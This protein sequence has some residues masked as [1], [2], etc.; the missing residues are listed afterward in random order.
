[1][2]LAKDVEEGQTVAASFNT[3]TLFTIAQDLT[4]MRVIAKVDEADIGEVK[5][6][7]RAT[8]TVDAYPND[9]FEGKVTQ[10]RQN[11]ETENNVV[12]YEVVISAPN[13]DLK[14]KPALTANVTLFTLEVDSVLSIPTKAFRFQPTLENL[15]KG[16]TIED[17]EGRQKIW[18]NRGNI[19]KAISIETGLTNGTRTEVLSGIN[20]GEEIIVGISMEAEAQKEAATERS[21]FAPGPPKKKSTKK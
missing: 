9:L 10:V 4:D 14:L 1:M 3:P 12:T 21:P 16:Y 5:E 18:T 13:P 8:F 11:G 20:E 19:V 6:G 15:P 7:Q 17:S 2:I